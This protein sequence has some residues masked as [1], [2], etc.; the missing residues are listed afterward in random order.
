PIK[1]RCASKRGCGVTSVGARIVSVGGQARGRDRAARTA[2]DAPRPALARPARDEREV[3][4]WNSVTIAES[5]TAFAM[6]LS[7]RRLE[8]TRHDGAFRRSCCVMLDMAASIWFIAART[9]ISSAG[10]IPRQSKRT[11]IDGLLAA[12]YGPPP[13]RCRPC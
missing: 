8:G 5:V 7:Q 13:L 12:T 9:V 3:M 6:P 11:P 4:A 10:S 2:I 1:Q